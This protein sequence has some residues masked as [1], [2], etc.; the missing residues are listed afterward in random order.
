MRQWGGTIGD[1]TQASEP[2]IT[3]RPGERYL[4]FLTKLTMAGAPE[5]YLI[6][7]GLQGAWLIDPDGTVHVNAP[8]AQQLDGKP[9]SESVAAIRA[10]LEA[11][12]PN[13]SIGG[14]GIVPLDKA[15]L[16]QPGATP[17]SGPP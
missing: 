16:A 10:A 13:D 4:L 9:L 11:G 1:C 3:F 14:S 8:Q 7:G 5:G 6:L 17:A 12:P 2:W 15:P